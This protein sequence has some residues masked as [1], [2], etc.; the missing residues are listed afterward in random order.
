MP[1]NYD[2]WGSIDVSDD[3]DDE[4]ESNLDAFLRMKEAAVASGKIP[5]GL[6]E[7]A[8][9]RG[10]PPPQLVDTPL[11]TLEAWDFAE[12][13]SEPWAI[14]AL[15]EGG[16]LVAERSGCRLVVLSNEDGS[17]VRELACPAGLEDVSGL[18]VTD[19]AIYLTDCG[20]HSIHKLALPDGAP[21]A[22]FEGIEPA[23]NEADT[24]KKLGETLQDEE[25]APLGALRYPRGCAAALVDGRRLLFVSDSG[26]KRIM[27]YDA[28]TLEPLRSVGAAK[29]APVWDEP[30]A[31]KPSGVVLKP[32]GVAMPMGVCVVGDTLA[33]VDAHEHRLSLYSAASGAFLR[34]V[35]REGTA[36]G[37]LRSAFDVVACN[38]RLVVGEGQRLQVLACDGTPNQVVSLPEA[39][40]MTGLTTDG[41]HVYVCDCP[42][43]AV[44]SLRVLE[45]LDELG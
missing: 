14:A 19:D 44:R 17:I 35:G 43:G 34:N 27:V 30:H 13:L 38:G 21:L 42:G 9:P 29:H 5:A 24:F 22:V 12:G 11:L 32:G 10:P 7:T 31:E 41:A 3:D 40:S 1:V 15:P 28:G 33:V 6:K 39:L 23:A 37:E 2:K 4:G 18:A 16:L 8:Q 36:P 45:D 25:E 26:H 20:T